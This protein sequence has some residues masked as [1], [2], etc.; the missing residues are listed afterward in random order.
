MQQW[1]LKMSSATNKIQ[2]A[3]KKK[4]VTL[5]IFNIKNL[6]ITVKICHYSFCCCLVT[7]FG[8]GNG[9][10]LQYCC[11]ENSM[12]GGAWWAAVHGVAKSRTW[13][14]DFT[15]TLH[16]HATGEEM[17][18]HSS[19]PVW[20]IPGT[21]EPGGL[22]SMGSHRVGHDWSDL[23]AAAVTKLC[24]TLVTPWTLASLLCPWDFPGKN[25][26]MGYHTLLQGIFPTQGLNPRLLHWQ[27]D[28]LPLTQ[29]QSP[30][31]SLL[32]ENCW[33]AF[34]LSNFIISRMYHVVVAQS[35]PT[36][37]DSIDWPTR[38]LCP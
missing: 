8:E 25:T 20:R 11:L 21:R 7:K 2:W 36:L 22:P 35:C 23:A 31:L 13:L 30:P 38:L 4:K 28:S 33:F 34:H 18:T 14:S 6:Y 12:D 16:F 5:K 24:L 37:C 1:R 17:A 29:L 19:V 10:P 27:V 15:F 3:K 26:G 9:T 32:P